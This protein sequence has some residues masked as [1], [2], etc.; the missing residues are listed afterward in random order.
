MVHLRSSALPCW[1]LAIAS[2][3]SSSCSAFSW[4]TPHTSKARL[5][6][7]TTTSTT[8]TTTTALFATH[9]R[10]FLSL[11]SVAAASLLLLPTTPAVASVYLDPA[12]YGDQE[13]RVA[14]VDSLR[15][16]VRQAILKNP[17][18][19]PSF[20]QLAL[21]DGLSYDPISK[22]GGPDGR[23]LRTVLSSK[24]TDSYTK[25]LQEACNVLIQA[26]I[27]LT[28]YTAIT[29]PDAVAI[30]GAEA[31]ESIGGPVLSVQLGRTEPPKTM[32]PPPMDLN[33][34]NGQASPKQ[35]TAL[36]RRAGLTDREM[37]TLLGAL[38]TLEAVPTNAVQPKQRAKYVERGKMG[39]MSDYKKLSD[40]DFN[41]MAEDD[42][43]E[44][45]DD[46]WYI[47]DSFGT[48]DQAFGQQVAAGIDQKTF[49]K[50]LKELNERSVK[51]GANVNNPTDAA[52][53][54]W[55]GA[56]LLD[57]DNPTAQSWLNKYGSS[58]LSY[59]K[60]LGIAYNAVTQ[61]GAE[62]TGGKY[63]NLLKNKARKTLNDDEFGLGFKS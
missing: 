10:D 59:L 15:E 58:N 51:K 19:A 61:L 28:K 41:A 29:I 7:V 52:T 53:V 57:N 4:N 14:A 50:Y 11:S 21:L 39:R 63:E 49:N 31:I 33:I 6:L 32:L 1:L 3:S 35:I 43:D 55:I 30:A 8:T 24:V 9:R 22:E 60:D 47:A 26:S 62:Y 23:I 2:S 20:F 34:F 38:L 40:D 36:F 25:N 5:S 56:V 45:P 42:Y 17:S 37:T 44:D 48:R 13:N 12:M 16:R 27:S 46:G 54:G 18:L